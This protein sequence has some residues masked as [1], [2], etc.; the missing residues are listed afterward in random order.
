MAFRML[1]DVP[2]VLPKRK[3]API[4][5]GV[6]EASNPDDSGTEDAVTEIDD[7]D[8]QDGTESG[9]AKDF[10]REGPLVDEDESDDDGIA[11][12]SQ[13]ALDPDEQND[14]ETD[15][16]GNGRPVITTVDSVEAPKG[17]P[18]V[19]FDEP[20]VVETPEVAARRTE[21]GVYLDKVVDVLMSR[22][23]PGRDLPMEQKAAG[24]KGAVTVRVVIEPT[25]RVSSKE[26]SRSSGNPYLDYL[27][28]EAIPKKLPRFHPEM[29]QVSLVYPATLNWR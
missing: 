22:W 8:D 2:Q 29:E 12:V 10:E 5:T 7:E 26:V 13:E 23:N 17:A 24:V 6:K 9:E 27:A 16:E 21:R 20:E 28:M 4:E 19:V 11:E 18:P 14:A 25:G 15:G 3:L 1:I